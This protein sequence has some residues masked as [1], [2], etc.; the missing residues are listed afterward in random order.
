MVVNDVDTLLPLSFPVLSKVVIDVGTWLFSLLESTIAFED[1]LSFQNEILSHSLAACSRDLTVDD[2]IHPNPGP[3]HNATRRSTTSTV[4]KKIARFEDVTVA[5]SPIFPLPTIQCREQM[6]TSKVMYKRQT[7][8][9]LKKVAP[10]D[11]NPPLLLSAAI[12]QMV[13]RLQDGRRKRQFLKLPFG[14]IT[15]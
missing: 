15:F 11:L 10:G 5:P 12:N 2:E 13:H 3:E 1:S 9:R 4:P 8:D 7:R 6:K 14:F